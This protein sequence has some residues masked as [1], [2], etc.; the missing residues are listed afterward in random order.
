MR[1]CERWR[2]YRGLRSGIGREGR[3]A[4]AGDIQGLPKSECMRERERERERVSERERER[5]RARAGRGGGWGQRARRE[6][7]KREGGR[8]GVCAC[9]LCQ[10]AAKWTA[11]EQA[12]VVATAIDL[13]ASGG[14]NGEQALAMLADSSCSDGEGDRNSSGELAAVSS[15]RLGIGRRAFKRAMANASN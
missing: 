2:E 5:E 3:R 1:E 14:G 6:R 12:V 13:V 10:G 7:G 9:L 15:E 11:S 8:E 4:A